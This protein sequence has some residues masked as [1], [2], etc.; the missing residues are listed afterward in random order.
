MSFSAFWMSTKSTFRW[1]VSC[2]THTPSRSHAQGRTHT[3]TQTHARTQTHT[4]T[5]TYTPTHTYTHAHTHTH[6]RTLTPRA[7]NRTHATARAHADD[8]FSKGA[9]CLAG[10]GNSELTKKLEAA[11][12]ATR[13]ESIAVQCRA[14]AVLVPSLIPLISALS[15]HFR[16]SRRRRLRSRSLRKCRSSAFA[17]A[18]TGAVAVRT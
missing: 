9:T 3:H 6:T 15:S 17:A 5:H 2:A 16:V 13:R 10:L 14:F 11:A 12:A 1:S 4:H 7:R 8:I 18:L